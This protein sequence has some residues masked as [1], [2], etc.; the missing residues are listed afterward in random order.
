MGRVWDQRQPTPGGPGDRDLVA[1]QFGVVALWQVLQRGAG[2]EDFKRRV[3]AR[4]LH[5]LHRGVYAV[6]PRKALKREAHELAAVLACGPE[7]VLSH[8]TA[9]ARWGF[10][11]SQ[12][13]R[14]EVS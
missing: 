4:R 2:R 9:G 5:P 8:R 12:S 11:R 7:A 3:K 10:F 14:I 1:R 6:P 13:A